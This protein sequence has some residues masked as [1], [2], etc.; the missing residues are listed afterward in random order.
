MLSFEP[1]TAASFKRFGD[2]IDVASASRHCTINDGYAERY[3]DLARIDVDRE[4]GRPKLSIF[5]ALPRELPF[6][7]SVIERHP[8]GS[9]AF[10]PMSGRPYLV[11]VCEG[12]DAPD[13][14]TLRCFTAQAG[15]GVNYAPGTWHHPLLALEAPCD[16]LVIDRAGGGNNCDEARLAANDIWIGSAL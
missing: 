8:L 12:A 15:Q 14:G 2:V 1:L 4:G 7:L 10:I 5:R 13:L 3:D 9:Q 6:S 11:V 16:F